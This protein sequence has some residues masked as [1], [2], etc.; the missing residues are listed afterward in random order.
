MKTLTSI[1]VGIGLTLNLFTAKAEKIHNQYESKLIHN[2]SGNENIQSKPLSVSSL[3]DKIIFVDDD[4]TA[5]PWQGTQINPYNKIQDAINNAEAGDELWVSE[6]TYHEIISFGNGIK[7][8]GGFNGTETNRN[9]RNVRAY[10]TIIDASG[11]RTTAVSI[12]GGARIDGFTI[13][14]GG[15]P[16]SPSEPLLY[17]GGIS[18]SNAYISNCT[19]QGNKAFA[20]GGIQIESSTVENCIITGNS[21]YKRAIQVRV[22]SPPWDPRYEWILIGGFGGGIFGSGIYASGGASSLINCTIIG[23]S[24]EGSDGGIQ[25][26][27]SSIKNCIIWGN[28]PNQISSPL[29]PQY[30]CIQDWTDGGEGNI[31]EEPLF[32]DG[33][34]HLSPNSPCI[35]AG[36]LVEGL[37]H[38]YEGEPR[39]FN[40]TTLHRGDGSNFDI[41]ADE[42][43]STDIWIAK[44]NGNEEYSSGSNIEVIWNTN[45]QTAGT[46]I[47]YEL[48]N[49]FNKVADLGYGWNSWGHGREN[50]EL[51]QNIKS[52]ADYRI[53]IISTWDPNFWDESDGTFSIYSPSSS[54]DI[55]H[56][57]LYE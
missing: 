50:I 10:P 4:N 23:N 16:G 51:P 2:L 33:N 5:G 49:Q 18:G 26:F 56:W 8:Y 1:I 22:P 17:G 39:G 55:K 28:S 44:P 30:S 40:A 45:V 6:G 35:D 36:G 32:R 25:N 46:G 13:I 37:T 7:L 14:N 34:Y 31:S 21:V 54:V 47:K 20:G 9:L 42:Y 52:K 24:A 19:I 48:W 15:S 41:G 12:G 57:N 38:D 11:F 3:E 29:T 53:R 43:L 27:N